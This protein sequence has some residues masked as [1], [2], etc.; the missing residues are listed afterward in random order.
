M[1]PALHRRRERS[2]RT[3]G[4][5]AKDYF[6]TAPR[7][8][9]PYGFFGDEY[10]V[11]LDWAR[12]PKAPLLHLTGLSGSGKS[13]LL[14][15]YLRPRL[16]ESDKTDDNNK[17]HASHVAKSGFTTDVIIIRSYHDPLA[18][19]KAELLRYWKQKPDDYDDLTP[20]AALRRAAQ[21]LGTTKRLLV[22]FDQF[23]E[24]FLVRLS[25]VKQPVK[26][27]GAGTMIP[28]PAV[29]QGELDRLRDFMS[30]FCK[31]PPARVA[32]LISYRE[33]LHRLLAPLNLPG[34]NDGVNR[35][36]VEPLDF[37]AASAFLRKCPGLTVPEE[38]MQ[39]VLSE[40]ARQEQG[41]VV[42]R[43]IVANLLGI[44]LRQISGH[45]TLWQRTD[46]LLRGYVRDCL[47]DEVLEERADSSR[48]AYRLQYC[49]A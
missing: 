6:D 41:R 38:R 10:K 14:N 18:S 44:I 11:F 26:A 49:Q 35:M 25:T 20:L 34:R 43:P 8:N 9:D 15:A 2:L 5:G 27:D 24:F 19:L 22:A 7:E 13:S 42:M 47:G 32:L 17:T 23:E 40:A 16:A 4:Q 45:P 29:A 39:C 30:S 3:I 21:Q 1:I 36:N 12:E 46:D 28:A 33:D 31:E 37:A 48:A